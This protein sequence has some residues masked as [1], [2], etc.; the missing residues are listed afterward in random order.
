MMNTTTGEFFSA[1]TIEELFVK[2]PEHEL[3]PLFTLGEKVT[4]TNSQ[5]ES[6]EFKID[7]FGD[8]FTTLK[9]LGTL[10]KQ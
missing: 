8:K 1:S 9:A 3:G 10:E 5:G 6:G 7:R 2:I 4:V